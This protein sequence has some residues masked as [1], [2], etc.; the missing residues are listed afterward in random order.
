MFIRAHKRDFMV[1]DDYRNLININNASVNNLSATNTIS[2]K[3]LDTDSLNTDRATVRSTLTVPGAIIT[4]NLKVTNAFVDAL[5]GVVN[6]TFSY[7]GTNYPVKGVQLKRLVESAH[8]DSL[9]TPS[10]ADRPNPRAKSC[11]LHARAQ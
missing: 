2:S 6:G 8:G 10:G 3:S 4:G 9:N 1:I 5:D 11:D 7:R